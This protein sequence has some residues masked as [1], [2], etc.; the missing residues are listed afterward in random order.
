MLYFLFQNETGYMLNHMGVLGTYVLGGNA[1]MLPIM[2]ALTVLSLFIGY[3]LGSVNFAVLFSKKLYG[4]DVRDSG[5]GNAGFTNMMRSYGE[6]A[7]AY[8]F[9][10][11]FL[12]AAL[13]V[14]IGWMLYG[15]MGAWS[16]ALGALLGHIFPLYYKFRG[17]KGVVCLT[18]TI[19]LLDWR[20]FVI[21]FVIFMVAA[22][23]TR[24]ISLGS[25]LC[26]ATLPLFVNRMYKATTTAE[27]I[28]LDENTRLK[29][30]V[31]TVALIMAVIVVVKHIGNIKRIA[32]GTESKFSFNK[33]K[34][35]SDVNA[36]GKDKQA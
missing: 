15:Y 27:G 16:G 20:I 22:V 19:L 17:G 3:L 11:D 29:W 23:S 9:V 13:A 35:T 18:A 24:Y 32:N 21:L 36:D 4:E 8:T 12:K 14:M 28:I 1:L 33:T 10:G 5:S 6:K 31:T 30:F 2:L 26:A 34:K 25:I 7:A